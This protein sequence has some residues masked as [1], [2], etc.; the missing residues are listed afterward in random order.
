[1]EVIRLLDSKGERVLDSV[2]A[3]YEDSFCLETFGDLI[4]AHDDCEPKGTRSFIIA[5][6]QTWDHKQPDSKFFSYY[7]AYHL[8]K[9]LFQT[10]IYLDKKLIHR[11]NVL[12]PLSNTDIIGNVQYF[13]VK[14]SR[15]STCRMSKAAAA[16]VISKNP[17]PARPASSISVNPPLFPPTVTATTTSGTKKPEISIKT[18]PK[19]LAPHPNSNNDLPPPSPSVQKIEAGDPSSWTISSPSV[20]NVFDEENISGPRAPNNTPSSATAGGIVGKLA[21]RLSHL[22]TTTTTTKQQQQ[23]GHNNLNKVDIETGQNHPQSY[24]IKALV[25]PVHLQQQPQMSLGRGLQN[26]KVG[27]PEGSITRFARPVSMND[28]ALIPA[29]QKSRRRALSYL[30]AMNATGQAVSFEDWVLMVKG[31]KAVGQQQETLDYDVVNPFGSPKQSFPIKEETE[32]EQESEGVTTYDAFLFATDDDFLESSKV[33]A[34][35]RDNAVVADE[36]KLFEMT[37]VTSEPP[38]SP[39]LRRFETDEE[40]SACEWCFPSEEELRK[41]SSLPRFFHKYKCYMILAIFIAI[42][43]LL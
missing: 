29:T 42:I 39:E 41:F 34:I 22:T 12:N 24:T 2:S 11:L 21:K 20:A 16:A 8:N 30:N 13:M 9:I 26:A 31:D 10:Q 23:K 14:T 38:E 25:S 27:I 37:P 4:A 33:R 17:D 35:F 19:F 1:M 18:A 36:A 43:A 3:E 7:N 15:K 6:V 5:R 40:V 28:A 32:D